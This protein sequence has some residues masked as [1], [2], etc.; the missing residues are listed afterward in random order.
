M[1]CCA[2]GDQAARGVPT[3]R[4][5]AC[6][7]CARWRKARSKRPYYKMKFES[8]VAELRRIEESPP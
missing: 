3:H 1:R 8:A 2:C 7:R 5:S 6:L 4:G